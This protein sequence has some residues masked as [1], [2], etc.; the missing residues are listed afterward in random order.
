MEMEK[1]TVQEI[2]VEN[3]ARDAHFGLTL[4]VEER[5]DKVKSFLDQGKYLKHL[6]LYTQL[7]NL[8]ILRFITF[9]CLKLIQFLPLFFLQGL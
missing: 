5:L 6:L 3:Q 9:R 7:S 1:K 4:F 2:Y 8:A